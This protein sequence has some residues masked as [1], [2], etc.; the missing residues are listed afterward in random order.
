MY[1]SRHAEAQIVEGP[2]ERWTVK[3]DRQ[4][5]GRSAPTDPTSVVANESPA[6]TSVT[7]N[8]SASGKG[9][10]IANAAQPAM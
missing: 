1:P 8:A 10:M 7:R 5:E 9:N 4:P 3:I 2:F 6:P